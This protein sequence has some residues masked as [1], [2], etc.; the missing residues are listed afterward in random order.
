MFSIPEL[1]GIDFWGGCFETVSKHA[2]CFKTPSG[3]GGGSSNIQQHPTKRESARPLRSALPQRPTAS[4]GSVHKY[5][6]P[7]SQFPNSKCRKTVEL[8]LLSPFCPNTNTPK[9]LHYLQLHLQAW[10]LRSQ[11][12][13]WVL[14]G[15]NCRNSCRYYEPCISSKVC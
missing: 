7:I 8:C 5:F 4:N 11:N 6:L 12:S 10:T 14:F 9:Q 1:L 2:L 3:E 15:S 13:F